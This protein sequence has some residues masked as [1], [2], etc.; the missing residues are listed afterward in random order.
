MRFTIFRTN[1]AGTGMSVQGV[2]CNTLI[3]SMVDDTT[4][5]IVAAY[6]DIF[7]ALEKPENWDR[8]NKIP[9]VCPVSEYY[10][11]KAGET[12]WRGLTGVV[13]LEIRGINN[14]LEL[15][16]AKNAVSV[17]PQVMAAFQGA[18]GYS[19][20]VLTRASLPNNAL[21]TTEEA[22][23]AFL[24]KAYATSV[25]CLQPTLEFPIDIKEPTL[26][27]TFLR[28]VDPEPYYNENAV[29]YVQQASTQTL[30]LKREGA[31]TLAESPL[32]N[33][34]PGYET[35]ATFRKVFNACYHRALGVNRIFTDNDADEIIA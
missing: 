13:M 31:R 12:V 26:D 20:V 4:D 35:F 28:T 27:A 23:L 10:R 9:R 8:Y 2:E 22:A 24:S 14:S 5:K 33:M 29:A 17:Y 30:P 11:N 7:L 19:L 6:R 3:D 16:K 32:A 1:K 34:K 21:P 15:Q 25:M 18:D